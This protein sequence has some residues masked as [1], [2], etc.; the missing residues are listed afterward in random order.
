MLKNVNMVAEAAAAKCQ[1]S[2]QTCNISLK[3]RESKS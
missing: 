1:K 3:A 2:V